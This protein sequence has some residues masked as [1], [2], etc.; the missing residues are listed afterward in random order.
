MGSKVGLKVDSGVGNKVVVGR[1]VVVGLR[2]LGLLVFDGDMLGTSVG[3]YVDSKVGSV[4]G[5]KVGTSDG[6][7][8]GALDLGNFEGIEVVGFVDGIAV[9]FSVGE[10]FD[11][12]ITGVN[13]DTTE[14]LIVG[15]LVGL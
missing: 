12:S 11:G 6:S 10:K 2:L 4:V 7:K 14:G 13:E 9:G 1:T 3:E 15:S 5:S 8:T